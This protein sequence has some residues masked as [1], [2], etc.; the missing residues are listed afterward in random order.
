MR[1][2]FAMC[3]AALMSLS[4][5]AAAQDALPI[6]SFGSCRIELNAAQML[7]RTE[8]L[9]EARRFD[10]AAPM[11][12]ALAQAPEM[13]LQ[14]RYLSGFVASEQGDYARAAD[15][16]KAILADDPN[17]TRV[18]LELA[19]AMLGMGQLQGAD[20]QFRMAQQDDL[21][22]DIARAVRGAREVIRSQ[23]LWRLDMDLGIAPDTN[24]NNATSANSVNIQFGDLSLPV[25]LD[26]E[27]R[28]KSGTGQVASL[29]AGVRLPV[30]GRAAIL[31]DL[32]GNG[33]N[34]V[35]RAYDDFMVQG[36]LGPQLHLSDK[37]SIFAQGLAAQRWYGGT[38]ASRQFGARFGGQYAFTDKTRA[39]LQIDARR[40]S[41]QFDRNFS[42]WQV[43]AYANAEQAVSRT[44]LATGGLFVR[45][46]ALL[47]ASY[48]NVELGGSLGIAG[49]L[50][51]GVNFA[52]N[53]TGSRAIFDAP[54]G[55]FS[56]DPRR[57]WRVGAN[58]SLGNRKLRLMGFS[59]QVNIGWNRTL[60]NVPIFAND[61]LRFRFA[62]ARYF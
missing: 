40:T 34:Y 20:R 12:A 11:I 44:M 45:R 56:R 51:W 29:N 59:P 18:R 39:G 14:S 8:Q 36:A 46:D 30:S 23:R 57:D 31:A 47:A 13:K 55:L 32:N 3:A 22:P 4:T 37:A 49:E 50:P 53:G 27:A 60:S 2:L 9:V 52:V 24:I 19:R 1:G 35:G 25:R 28:A 17:Q 26:D 43:G 7:A 54:M 48:S 10:E 6:C 16:F 62:A 61:R 33:T 58:L 5:S 38:D 15:I 42:G 41:A 21:P